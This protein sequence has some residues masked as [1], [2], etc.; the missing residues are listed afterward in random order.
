MKKSESRIDARMR[1][2]QDPALQGLAHALRRTRPGVAS[3]GLL[4]GLCTVFAGLVVWAHQARVDDVTR[5]EGRVLPSGRMQ[6]VQHLE[7]GLITAIH[8]KPGDEVEAGAPL[9]TL[10]PVQFE[11]ERDSRNEQVQALRARRA[12]LEAEATG[13]EPRFEAAGKDRSVATYLATERA[14]FEQRRA[15]LNADLATIGHLLADDAAQQR[16]LARSRRPHQ[17]QQLAGRAFED[18]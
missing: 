13:S 15:R 12:R 18:A 2:E 16:G 14:E 11:S 3:K 7:G 5:A 1:P 9:L 4:L 6:V 10:S 17:G 8:V